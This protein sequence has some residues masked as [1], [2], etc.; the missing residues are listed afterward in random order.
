MRYAT[1]SEVKD[2]ENFVY[3]AEQEAKKSICKK[4]QR[5]AV[6]FRG[7]DIIGIGYNKPTYER[8]CNPC[9]R[10]NIK[11]NS[12]IE[13]CSAIHAEQ[14]AIID[15]VKCGNR[16]EGSTM[17]HVKLKDGENKPC[18]KPSCTVCSRMVLESG[19]KEFIM[20]E[21]GGYAIYPSE[22]FNKLSFE[23]FLK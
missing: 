14:M 19:I 1:P 7:P 5:G 21:E 12:K 8:T 6:I 11:D 13:L 22:E 16:L 2:I 15:S 18:E 20:R 17:L 10:E 4:S 3:D 9:V 23:R